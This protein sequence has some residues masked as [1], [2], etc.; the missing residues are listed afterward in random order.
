M[1]WLIETDE[2]LNEFLSNGFEEAFVEVIPYNYTIHPAQNGISSVYI[3]P[4][5]SHKGFILTV[6]HSETL[7]ISID[8]IKHVLNTFNKV[9]VRDKKEFLHYFILKHAYDITLSSP[10]YISVFTQSHVFFYDKYPKLDLINKIIPIVKHH[11]YCEN[12][13]N[14]LK[15]KINDPINDFYNT[16]ASLVFNAIERNGIHIDRK[17]FDEYFHDSYSNFVYTQYNFKTTTRRPSNKFNGV[18]YGALNKDNG[19]RQCFIPNND[20]LVEIDLSAYHPTLLAKLINYDFKGENIYEYLSKIYGTDISKAK[21]LTFKQL[22]GG[23]YPQYKEFEFFRKTQEYTD[24]IW[25]KF[26]SEGYIECPISKYKFEKNK[27][28]E[29][30][31]QKLLNYLLQSLETSNNVCILWELFRILKDKKTKLI[32]YVYDSFLLDVDKS[33]KYILKEILEVFEKH[34]L[35]TKIKV[36]YNYNELEIVNIK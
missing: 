10:P 14:D 31:P 2:Q 17:K 13:F 27:L 18:N 21:E 11:E 3:R 1:Y 7:S 29:I 22:Y 15:D 30:N 16:R 4:L 32:L 26:N 6:D 35:K 24:E 33:E 9:Y 34:N 19:E 12:I 25:E 23:I 36:G 20:L 5:K 8:K 28:E